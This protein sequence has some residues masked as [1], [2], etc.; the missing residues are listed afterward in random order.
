MLNNMTA[1][2]KRHQGAWFD[3][4]AL[5]FFNSKFPRRNVYPVPG[6]AFFISSEYSKGVYISTGWIP[7]GPVRWTV[8]FCNDENGSISNASKFH[9]YETLK[10][11]RE[12]A[13]AFRNAYDALK[14]TKVQP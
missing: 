1:I 12:A 5:R 7:D 14:G 9:E 3:P 11:A 8:R 4:G 13:K 10:E 6:G 2:R